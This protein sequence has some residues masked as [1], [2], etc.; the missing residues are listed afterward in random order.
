MH[1]RERYCL[2]HVVVQGPGS[3]PGQSTFLYDV[4]LRSYGASNLPNFRILAFVGGTCAPPGVLLVLFS[5]E[6]N[7]IP[8]V[9]KV[10]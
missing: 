9:I 3:F 2:L 4:W 1:C 10:M 8:S 5:A 6:M 7:L